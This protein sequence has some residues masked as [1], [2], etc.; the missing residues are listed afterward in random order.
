MFYLTS[1]TNVEIA[2]GKLVGDR[3]AHL[4]TSGE[5]G[6]GITIGKATDNIRVKNMTI[7]DCWGDGI[8]IGSDSSGIARNVLIENV[9]CDNNRRQGLTITQA[10]NVTVRNSIFKNTNGISP[11]SGLDIEPNT[12]CHVKN[13]TVKNCQFANNAGWGLIINGDNGLYVSAVNIDSCVF[14]GNAT[15][16]GVSQSSNTSDISYV[17]PAGTTKINDKEFSQCYGLN[18]ITIPSSVTSIGSGAFRGCK[19]LTSVTIPNSVTSIGLEAFKNCTGL[20]SVNIPA[21]VTTIDNW[22]FIGCSNLKSAYFYGNA[23]VTTNYLFYNCP[24]DFRV[25]YIAGKTGFTSPTWR[26][27]PASTFVP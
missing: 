15:G 10:E 6:M 23:P 25:Y 9:V 27:Y 16:I 13:V 11:Q 12:G 2:G 5:H 3:N 20:T 14:S 22:A 21:S 7:R 17:I 8:Y 19:A 24:A 4:S 26:G 1:V 18:K